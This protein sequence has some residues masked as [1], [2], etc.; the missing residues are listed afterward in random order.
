MT[1]AL[2]LLLGAAAF[3]E[4]PLDGVRAG[5]IDPLTGT[6]HTNFRQADFDGDGRTDLLFPAGPGEPGPIVAVFQTAGG[7]DPARREAVPLPR[8]RVA[9]D[10]WGDTVYG[11]WPG[12]LQAFQWRDGRWE[13]VFEQK[14][15][16]PAGAFEEE[17]LDWAAFSPVV[18]GVLARFLH[19]LDGDGSPE[20]LI[21]GPAGL[22]V[23][24]RGSEGYQAGAPLDVYP[25]MRLMDLPRQTLWPPDNRHIAFPAREMFC[26]TMLHANVLSVVTASE[27]GDGVRYQVARYPLVVAGAAVMIDAEGVQ[28]TRTPP[29]PAFMQPCRLNADGD[30][31]FAG[32]T[33]EFAQASAI[34]MPVHT[35]SV[36]TTGGKTVEH[37][38]AAFFRPHTLFV[39][40]NGDGRLDLV[41]EETQLYTG[42]AR[43]IISRLLTSRQIQHT[44][45]VFAQDAHGAF[46][47]QP[48]VRRTFTIDLPQPPFRNDPV[49]QDYQNAQLVN[50]TGDFNGDGFRDFVVRERPQTL[51][52]YLSRGHD[53]GRQPD[54]RLD[55]GDWQFGLAD[56][57]GD[58]RTDIV[59]T[60]LTGPEDQAL[61]RSRVFLYREDGP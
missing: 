6:A 56:V 2:M 51:S 52:I 33:W 35:T 39:D 58:G 42:G 36:T 20:I 44:V 16:W 26:R 29:F 17:S 10:I 32:G 34:P 46:A 3:L 54:V 59:C 31:D 40:V 28:I 14:M 7:F 53:H 61:V 15:D 11:K 30:V 5:G 38:R 47:K 45:S 37:R 41:T 8:Q 50:F 57:D 1:V 19:D 24:V 13:S 49:F 23:Y 60:R 25:S 4:Q 18:Q 48:L 22:H 12:R 27:T 9:V 21:P 43:E 55:I